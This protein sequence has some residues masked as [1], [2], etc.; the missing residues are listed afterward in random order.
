MCSQKLTSSIKKTFIV[1]LFQRKSRINNTINEDNK[2]IR[3][4]YGLNNTESDWKFP[5]C[6]C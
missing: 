3:N 5:P 2:T 6:H 1:S 4:K